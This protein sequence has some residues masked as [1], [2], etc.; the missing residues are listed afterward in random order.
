MWQKNS[1][2]KAHLYRK[3]IMAIGKNLKVILNKVVYKSSFKVL[4]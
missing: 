1:Q 2:N 3:Q 4:I